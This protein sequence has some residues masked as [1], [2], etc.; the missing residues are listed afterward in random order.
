MQGVVRSK[1][2][3][4]IP[5]DRI[6][7]DPHQPRDEFEPEAL[8]RL[9]ESLRTRGQLQPIRV[10]WDE[11]RGSYVIIC[12]ERRWRAAT[13]AGLETLQ[14]VVVEGPI[15]PA[16]LLAIQLV[17][18]ALREDLRPVEQARAY[19]TLMDQKGWSTRQ[20]A[21]ELAVAQ[22]Q[23]V[24]ALALLDLPEGVQEAVEQ[25]ALAPGTAYEVSKLDDARDQVEVAARVVEGRLTREQAIEAVKA[26]REGRPDPI[27]RASAAE[28]RVTPKVTVSVR[29]RGEDKLTVLQALRAAV[30]M[31]QADM[32][33]GTEEA[34]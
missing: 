16:E 20:I 18:N 22:P 12:G 24:R 33:R 4:E 21:R 29:Y 17:E 28:F 32:A 2:A 6:V 11:G 34:A 3:A 31:A 14:C 19:R 9:A 30:K 8:E 26:R 15:D 23:V 13:M 25:G 5:V 1:D 27:P 10:R 7:A